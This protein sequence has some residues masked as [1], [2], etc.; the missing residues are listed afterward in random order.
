MNSPH[1]RFEASCPAAPVPELGTMPAGRVHRVW[2]CRVAAG[3]V[4]R[5]RQ[6][7]PRF[8]SVSRVVLAMSGVRLASQARLIR[9]AHPFG[10]ACRQSVSLRSALALRT[11]TDRRGAPHPHGPPFPPQDKWASKRFPVRGIGC[12]LPVSLPPE[13]YG[14][15]EASTRCRSAHAVPGPAAA[16]AGQGIGAFGLPNYARWW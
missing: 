9:C 4:R 2:R 14:T 3:I 16:V 12:H 7:A 5:G 1:P 10:A 15:H 13:T 8:G 11:V 6:P